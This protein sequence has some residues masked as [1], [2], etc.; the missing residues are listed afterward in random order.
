MCYWHRAGM[1]IGLTLLLHSAPVAGQT[2]DT[3]AAVQAA[4][5]AADAWLRLVDDGQYGASWD[6][7]ASAFQGAVARETWEQAVLRARGPLEPFGARQKPAAHFTT[8]LPN[9]PAGQYVVLQYSTTVA[10]GR[11]ATEVVTP[12]LDGKRGWR[13]SGYFVRPQ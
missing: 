11:T 3:A 10:Q 9:A 7:A 12:M 4:T 2:V 5:A 13:V 8:Q 1:G 6:S